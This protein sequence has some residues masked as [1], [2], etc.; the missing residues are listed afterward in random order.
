MDPTAD[1][2]LA[3]HAGFL[4]RFTEHN[5]NKIAP[6]GLHIDCDN[7]R[8]WGEMHDRDRFRYHN[9][10]KELKLW[11]AHLSRRPVSQFWLHEPFRS[12]D[13]PSLIDLVHAVGLHLRFP[14]HGQVERAAT[15]SMQDMSKQNVIL[16][17]TLRFNH[18][19]VSV[20]VDEPHDRVSALLEQLSSLRVAKTSVLIDNHKGAVIE[21]Q[22][23]AQWLSAWRPDSLCFAQPEFVLPLLQHPATGPKLMQLGYYLTAQFLLVRFH[24]KLQPQPEDC[25]RLGPGACSTFGGYSFTNYADPVQYY[26]GLNQSRL[27]VYPLWSGRTAR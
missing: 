23:L 1:T 21:H 26:L 3:A 9:L 8:R 10:I 2:S 14:S 16:L 19:R 7:L 18:L 5:R 25:L 13:A 4:I 27:P 15:L 17:G 11:S 22:E 12:L 20:R 24:S 6:L